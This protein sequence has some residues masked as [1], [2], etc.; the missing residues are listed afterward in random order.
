MSPTRPRK[1]PRGILGILCSAFFALTASVALATS[2]ADIGVTKTNDTT[3]GAATAG[4]VI[5]YN[6]DLHNF[7]PNGA[8]KLV[9][10]DCLD[11]HLT[12]ISNNATQPDNCN[13]T[14]PPVSPV[15]C[16]APNT[17]LTCNLQGVGNGGD[18]ILTITATVD[19]TTPEGTTIT[20]CATEV[21]SQS[22]D[23]NSAN[24][25]GCDGGGFTI[26]ASAD[27]AVTKTQTAPDPGVEPTVPGGTMVTY[28]I[29][30]HNNGPDDA[31]NF[32]L[33]DSITAG[34]ATFVSVTNVMGG[35]DCST[36]TALPGQC[37][38]ATFSNGAD[39]SFDLTVTMPNDGTT[40][41]TD[42]ATVSSDTLDTITGNNTSNV[43]T[44]VCQSVDLAITKAC[45]ALC[46]FAA[47]SVIKPASVISKDDGL[48]TCP[49]P[50]TTIGGG[51]NFEYVIT[52]T[53]NDGSVTA[54]N[55]IL[56]DALPAGVTYVSDTASC[57]SGSIATNTCNLGSIPPGSSVEFGIVVTA[58]DS[59][60]IANTA[61]VAADQCDRNTDDN[62]S[63]CSVTASTNNMPT[64]LEADR[65]ATPV[66]DPDGVPNV[67]DL[68]RVFEPNETVRIDPAWTNTLDNDTPSDVTGV[69]SNF[70]A[71][72]PTGTGVSYT[73]NDDT[74][75]Y[76]VIPA[77]TQ[78]DCN[79]SANSDCYNFQVIQSDA[80]PVQHWDTHFDETLS[81]G[82]THH[83]TLHLGD[84]FTDVPR[85]DPFYRFIETIFHNHITVGCQPS[86]ANAF[87]PLNNAT[88]GESAA[89]ISRAIY[90]NDAAVPTSGTGWDCSSTSFF[91]DSFD[92]PTNQFYC[93]YANALHDIHIVNGCDGVPDFCFTAS[94]T[95]GDFAVMA[96]RGVSYLPPNN[97]TSDP[98]GG[99]PLFGN[100][101]A[102]TRQFN[103]DSVDHVDTV[104]SANIPAGTAPF[105]D[106]PC[107]NPEAKQIGYLWL[108]HTIDGDCAACD[109]TAHYRPFDLILRDEL[110]KIISNAFVALPLYGP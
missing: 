1:V 4:Q 20:N 55:V 85:S 19:P 109:G 100:D 73:E 65:E 38:L 74:A 86:S 89:F 29:A 72:D 52:V 12:N 84:S 63:E 88:R 87:C 94:V 105:A 33:G 9:V 101:A 30:A 81:T 48:P 44:D 60:P 106:V 43:T 77:H 95:R 26:V 22:T 15:V 98:D 34:S 93:H 69:A 10:Q 90:G 62:S 82:E 14:T 23:P 50:I 6:I 92:N 25:T 47:A 18:Q 58:V 32:V 80:R 108:N 13:T 79:A 45:S 61:S 102:D 7:G 97:N 56:T 83:W 16:A 36:F 59:G 35:L 96:A 3:G 78:S 70:G 57:T 54:T 71:G 51:Q 42:T 107:S 31:T 37:T 8:S 24:N 11:S 66:S 49:S 64:A 17:T 76:G 39:A 75:D 2:T 5:H 68:N 40:A 41:V 21:S 104:S 110:A 91:A 27:L 67:S 53:N 103:C 28:H 46:D 99:I